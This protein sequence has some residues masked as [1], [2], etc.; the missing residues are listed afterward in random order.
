M[1]DKKRNSK[2]MPW[3]NIEGF[4]RTAEQGYEEV[5]YGKDTQ[6]NIQEHEFTYLV[7]TPEIAKEKVGV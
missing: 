4:F 5:Y 6:F 2:A 1:D 7:S 3:F